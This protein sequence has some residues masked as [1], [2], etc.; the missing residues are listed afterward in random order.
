MYMCVLVRVEGETAYM[1]VIKIWSLRRQYL[2]T[3]PFQKE[4]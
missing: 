1:Y 4:R 3:E 2:T